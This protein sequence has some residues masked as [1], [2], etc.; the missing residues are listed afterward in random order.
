MLTHAHC[1]AEAEYILA[2]SLYEERFD[3]T[4]P[5]E[6]IVEA[7]SE[8]GRRLLTV[9][10]TSSRPRVSNTTGRDK[11]T[12]LVL[13]AK[14]VPGM[15]LSPRAFQRGS[16]FC[17]GPGSVHRA[18]TRE[19]G[20]TMLVLWVGSQ[21]PV[22][23]R[24][25]VPSHLRL[26]DNKSYDNVVLYGAQEVFAAKRLETE[27]K[28]ISRFIGLQERQPRPSVS[29]SVRDPGRSDTRAAAKSPR[30][31]KESKAVVEVRAYACPR[32][33]NASMCS[34]NLSSAARR[35]AQRGREDQVLHRGSD[36]RPVPQ[37][38]WHGGRLRVSWRSNR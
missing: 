1:G 6:Q 9:S 26:T 2:G 34:L 5:L 8:D 13:D 17:R 7:R 32:P 23:V 29:I 18:Y 24:G 16:V 25:P 15:Q 38:P 10:C 30:V 21:L 33:Y 37:G 3:Y 12:E 27:T 11:G 31:P 22:S 20:C 36:P 35:L 14:D 19:D 4:F 28:M